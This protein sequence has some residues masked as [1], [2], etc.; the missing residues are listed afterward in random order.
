MNRK[1]E[2]DPRD[3]QRKIELI[4]GRCILIDIYDR[5]NEMRWKVYRKIL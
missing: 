1:M 3:S 2:K 4:M 5:D